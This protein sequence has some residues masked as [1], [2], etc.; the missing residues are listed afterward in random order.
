M[1]QLDSLW[2]RVDE[3]LIEPWSERFR[4]ALNSPEAGAGPEIALVPVPEHAGLGT[5]L[6]YDGP[7]G[8]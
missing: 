3:E 6:W 7:D 1:K 2:R 8:P 4:A 5:S